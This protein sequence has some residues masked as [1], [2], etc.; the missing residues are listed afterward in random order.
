MQTI[1]Y[2]EL[3]RA[4]GKVT[5]DNEFY[6]LPD[7]VTARSEIL[8]IIGNG[9]A[10][11]VAET[12]GKVSAMASKLKGFLS[13]LELP[14]ADYKIHPITYGLINYIDHLHQASKDFGSDNVPL[15]E[16]INQMVFLDLDKVF[17]KQRS[18]ILQLTNVGDV[19]RVGLRCLREEKEVMYGSSTTESTYTASQSL[20]L[21]IKNS[22]SMLRD[23]LNDIDKVI[24]PVDPMAAYAALFGMTMQSF[25]T[26]D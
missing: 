2:E 23:E 21:S 20:A 19:A 13:N 6:V 11:S 25:S 4:L 22:T 5:V 15:K 17:D 16:A 14:V 7:P 10:K 8:R 18:K 9:L 3:R 24:A 1:S 12:S 26:E